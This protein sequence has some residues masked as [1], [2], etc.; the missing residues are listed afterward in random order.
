VNCKRTVSSR[1]LKTGV[2]MRSLPKRRKGNKGRQERE[3]E[4]L[5][6]LGNL[7]RNKIKVSFLKL[8]LRRKNNFFPYSQS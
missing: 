6:G 7:F 1:R 4:K 2:F 5:F 3:G 8:P